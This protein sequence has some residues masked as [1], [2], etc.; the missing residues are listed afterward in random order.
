FL[1]GQT[2]VKPVHLVELMFN[3]R[4]SFPL[5]KCADKEFHRQTAYSTSIVPAS[6]KYARCSI[7]SWATQMIGK[8]VHR[9][10]ENA[11][12]PSITP[13][14]S[15]STPIIPA[16]LVASANERTKAKG[17]QVVT[18]DLL[19]S[20][21]INDR[22]EFFKR[23]IPVAWYL[24]E[25]MAARRQKGQLV[26]AKRRPPAI[27]QVASLSSFIMSRNQYANGYWAM[28]I[29]I[30]HVACQTHIDIMRGDCLKGSSVHKTTAMTALE[31]MADH[32]LNTLKAEVQKGCSQGQV[33]Y[34]YVLDNI[35]QF[36][37]VWEG[38]IGRENCL[39]CG[40]AGTA[41]AMEDVAPGAF[42][43]D[44]YFRRVLQNK[45][46]ELTVQ[47]LYDIN[48]LFRNK[49]ALHR[50]REGRKSKVVPLGTNSEHKTDTEGMKRALHDFFSQSGLEPQYASMFLA[51][52]GGDGGSVLAM[53]RAKQYLAQH[54]D[55][56]D[57]HSDYKILHNLL[58]TIGIWHTQST[59]QNTITEN[60]YG[61]AVTDDPSALN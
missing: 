38:G 21:R 32:S 47:K 8:H 35:Q 60:H 36:L 48:D 10:M 4:Y 46:S 22:I 34:R 31:T 29:G 1:Q 3:H 2:Q 51:W 52:V 61:P 54:Y 28:Q 30:W 57:S 9:E 49:Y 27:I 58:P 23:S 50:M 18:K 45:R 37:Q 14:N 5:H 44:D 55:P 41:I 42:D 7:S 59:N 25:C 43:L 56:E 20:F 11:I 33:R 13:D 16:R 39:V 6:I 12:Y 15:D 17:V 53:D 26:E 19:L 40:C 24:M